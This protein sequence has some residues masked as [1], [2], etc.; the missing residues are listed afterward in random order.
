MSR[1]EKRWCWLIGVVVMV[2]L[3]AAGCGDSEPI[4]SSDVTTTS[5]VDDTAD[6]DGAEASGQCAEDAPDCDDTSV[7]DGDA[8][9]GSGRS[10]P[11]TSDGGSEVDSSSGMT[12][13]G[14][15][16]VSEALGT[17]ATGVLAVKGHLYDEGAGSALRES[18]T[19][20]GERYICGGPL[21]PVEGLDL[22]P[23]G[24]AVIIHDGLTYTEDEITVLG[25]LVDG[26]LVVDATAS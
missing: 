17:D 7:V 11:E 14:G 24:D 12:V 4:G 21:L 10:E 13:D 2:G 9:A 22:G 5:E 23:I 6:G 3:L 18:L 8:G 15:L 25:E 20:G 19:G 16:T 1:I 26:I